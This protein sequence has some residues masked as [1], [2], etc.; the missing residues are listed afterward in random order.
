MIRRERGTT[1][2]ELL[3]VLAIIALIIGILG[4][5]IFQIFDITGW[6]N[7]EL[8]VQHDLRNAA[9]WLNRDVLMA[10]RAKVSGSQMVL[11]V[12]YSVSVGTVLTYTITYTFSAVDGTLTRDTG[13]SSHVV[14]RHIVSNPFPLTGT[15]EAPNVVT[16][17]LKST[18]GDVPGS[19]TFALKMRPGESISAVALCRV[20]GA[21][22][23]EFEGKTVS[24]L[25]TNDGVTSPSIDEIYIAWPITNEGLTGIWLDTNLIWA[26]LE[27][28]P[29]K[30]IDGPWLLQSREIISGTQKMLKFTFETNVD[31]R[32]YLYSIAITL[33]DRCTF[34]FP[35]NP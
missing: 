21:D 4:A 20:K 35:P 12:P 27:S 33:T 34:S 26:G 23:L 11:T 8:V 13:N 10:S 32:E 5:V 31:N 24:W 7:S 19:G 2:V 3:A 15:I 14:G 29:P 25:I 17:T 9:T 6:G 1:L 30:T 22:D 28:P 18:K 16:V